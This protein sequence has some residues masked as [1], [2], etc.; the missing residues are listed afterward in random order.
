M[1]YFFDE[2]GRTRV[3]ARGVRLY[4]EGGNPRRTTL[5]GKIAIYGWELGYDIT[6][7]VTTAQPRPQDGVVK[8]LLGVFELI[9]PIVLFL[10]A[11]SYECV[12][13]YKGH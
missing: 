1:R 4:V 13:C 6:L 10:N 11:P 2:Q 7:S 8:Q 5:I 12:Y 9:I 3:F